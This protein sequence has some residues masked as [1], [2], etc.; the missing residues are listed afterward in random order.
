MRQLKSEFLLRFEAT[1]NPSVDVGAGAMGLRAIA[2]VSGGTFEGPRLKGTILPSGGDWFIINPALGI[3]NVDVRATLQT[4]DGANIFAQYKG[5]ISAPPEKFLTLFDPTS[6]P[7][8]PES[9]YFRTA[10]TFET[11]SEK[12]AWLN[13]IQAVGIGEVMDGGVGYDVH[14]IL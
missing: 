2:D 1:L 6:G 13:G 8:D 10:P 5:R 4:D 11:G 12:Y 14:M 3:L 9:Y 7:P